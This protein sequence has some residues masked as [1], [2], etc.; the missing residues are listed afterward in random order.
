MMK[1]MTYRD[2]DSYLKQWPDKYQVE[3]I[4]M[5]DSSWKK[6]SFAGYDTV[7]HVAGIAHS[8]NGKISAEKEKRHY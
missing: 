8:D 3:T 1:K 6:K 5:I 7:F 4:D 2:F